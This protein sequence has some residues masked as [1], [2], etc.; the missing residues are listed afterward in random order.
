MATYLLATVTFI[1]PY[2]PAKIV[3]QG[4]SYIIDYGWCKMV[5]WYNKRQEEAEHMRYDEY[6]IISVSTDIN[7]LV[8]KIM[9]PKD[10]EE[11]SE[12]KYEPVFL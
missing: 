1:W 12:G 8:T 2:L 9:I 10:L 11:E 5:E 7:G 4:T 3:Y 6:E